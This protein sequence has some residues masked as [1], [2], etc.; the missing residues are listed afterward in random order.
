MGHRRRAEEGGQALHT[1]CGRFR[2]HNEGKNKDAEN[3]EK[4]R[5]ESTHYI[6][7]ALQIVVFRGQSD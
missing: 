2:E 3:I 4:W 1:E 5:T 6:N 7:W